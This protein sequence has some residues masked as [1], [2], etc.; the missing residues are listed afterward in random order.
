M[1]GEACRVLLG[2]G[3]GCS[4]GTGMR[5]RKGQLLSGWRHL[6]SPLQGQLLERSIPGIG[7]NCAPKD[8]QN[9][10]IEG[11]LMG[12]GPLPRRGGDLHFF[13]ESVI[14]AISGLD[15]VVFL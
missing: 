13:L 7:G 6:V 14:E 4:G 12:M 3:G 1:N 9:N 10:N 8:R 5:S 2:S 15:P 11:C